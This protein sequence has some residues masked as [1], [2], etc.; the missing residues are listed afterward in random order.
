MPFQTQAVHPW[1]LILTQQLNNQG[2]R[3]IQVGNYDQAIVTL[4]KALKLWE[5]V[6]VVH[7]TCICGSCS[8]DEC[9]LHTTRQDPP[10]LADGASFKSFNDATQLCE[11][12]VDS[13]ERFIY[14]G[15][16]YAS[17]KFMQQG[18]SLG[19]TLSL[20][21]ILNLAMAH[22]LSAMQNQNCRRRLQKAL[23]LY[24]LAHHLQM[25]ENEDICSPRVTMI[26]TNNVGEI[27]RALEN[28]CKHNM[29][30][31]HLLNTMMYMI[32]CKIPV[33]T[34]ELEGFVRNTSQLILNKHC[35]APPKYRPMASFS[36]T[37]KATIKSP[38]VLLN[39]IFVSISSRSNICDRC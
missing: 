32:D 8:L 19:V 30:L 25:E 26:I 20:I 1:Q 29:C 13:E 23:Q 31:Q 33:S 15:P 38:P 28:Q 14:R 39:F 4:V 2:A 3:C 5:Q 27:Y 21:I 11:D 10:F 24:E 12:M 6:A 22:H 16:I 35:K 34:V 9:I 17:P 36:T 37:L 18:H 7:N